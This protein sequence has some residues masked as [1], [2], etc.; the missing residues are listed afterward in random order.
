MEKRLVYTWGKERVGLIEK[1]AL[2]HIHYLLYKID[3]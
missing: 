1:A 2:K 3:S